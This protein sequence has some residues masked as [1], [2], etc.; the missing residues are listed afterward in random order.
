MTNDDIDLVSTDDLVAALKKRFD[1]C[2][3]LARTCTTVDSTRV[4]RSC[5]GDVVILLGLA[6][7]G[8]VM[9]ISDLGNF[10]NGATPFEDGGRG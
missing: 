8:R 9:A 7:T 5:K 6:E 3:F 4:Y 10:L 2:L 1:A